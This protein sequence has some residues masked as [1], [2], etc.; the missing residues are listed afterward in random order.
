MRCPI[1][2]GLLFGNL[3]PVDTPALVERCDRA[4]KMLTGRETTLPDFRIDISG[5]SP[6]VG[7]A[8]GDHLHLD[9]SGAN[10]QFIL[11]T[12]AQKTAPLPNAQ[13]STLR[14]ILRALIEENEP[15]LFALTA[16]DAV[17]GEL[18]GTVSDLSPP[19]RPFDIRKATVRADTTTAQ[20]AEARRPAERIHRFRSGPD[21][22][23]HGVLIAEM[24]GLAGVT[25]DD[26][27]NPIG[28]PV[29]SFEQANVRTSHFGGLYLF[30]GLPQPAVVSVGRKERPG[31]FPV[32]TVLD[33]RDR[34][35]IARVLERNEPV[36]PVVRARG[37]DSA[38]ILHQ[39]MGFILLDAA[40]MPGVDLAGATRRDLRFAGTPGAAPPQAFLG[41]AAPLRWV[42]GGGP[43]PRI[44]S[45]HPACLRSL[46]ARP[47]PT[48]IW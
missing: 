9:P 43:W 33:F 48:A 25:G 11:L 38:A 2:R 5:H 19:A 14:A 30:R 29:K 13:V 31:T 35:G 8:F 27:R 17:A 37:V 4:L 1:E 3:V 12:T 32:E 15:Q 7:D 6:E 28:L 18:D 36:E 47:M 34:N 10:R 20:V 44:T 21:A 22:W 41:L 40:A 24:I 46:R 26:T 39:K 23:R 42:E 16:R 45:E